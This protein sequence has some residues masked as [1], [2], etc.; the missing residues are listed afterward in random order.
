MTMAYMGHLLEQHFGAA[1]WSGGK[2]D[3]KFTN[4]LWPDDHI[5]I[6]GVATGL[7]QGSEDREEVFAWIEKDD[8]SIVLIANASAPGEK[9]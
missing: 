4:P 5:R 3:I 1:W 9:K 7:I 2:L 8:G 6:K